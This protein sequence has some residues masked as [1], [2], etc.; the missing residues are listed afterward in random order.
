M[1]INTRHEDGKHR[2]RLRLLWDTS[3]SW[4]QW[5]NCVRQQKKKGGYTKW[6]WSAASTRLPDAR[7]IQLTDDSTAAVS[8]TSFQARKISD[9]MSLPV[10]QQGREVGMSECLNLLFYYWG[11]QEVGVCRAQAHSNNRDLALSTT[12][13]SDQSGSSAGHPRFWLAIL[14]IWG[15]RGT[16]PPRCW[17]HFQWAI[18]NGAMQPAATYLAELITHNQAYQERI[19][20]MV[21]FQVFAIDITITAKCG[22]PHAVDQSWTDEKVNALKTIRPTFLLKFSILGLLKNYRCLHRF[23]SLR[24]VSYH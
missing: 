24:I 12:C 4:R 15:N 23:S 1:R 6:A 11:N 19:T 17:L 9:K 8:T 20:V 21:F 7:S 22:C 3:L 2:N 13:R 16:F 10:L 14:K 18:Y 5:I